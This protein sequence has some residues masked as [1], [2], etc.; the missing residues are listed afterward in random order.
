MLLRKSDE[1]LNLKHLF[2]F[3]MCKQNTKFCVSEHIQNRIAVA[4]A[5]VKA[6]MLRVV[7]PVRTF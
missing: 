7:A 6:S 3:V 4:R 5:E 1:T 2:F